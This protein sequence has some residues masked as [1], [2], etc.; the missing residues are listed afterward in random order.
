MCTPGFAHHV[1]NQHRAGGGFEILPLA[2]RR[3]ETGVA[4]VCELVL[5][6][7]VDYSSLANDNHLAGVNFHF[8]P[9]VGVEHFWFAAVRVLDGQSHAYDRQ[10]RIP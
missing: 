1:G 6:Q 2:R 5:R 10:Y 9:I 4:D 3:S 7:V 8:W